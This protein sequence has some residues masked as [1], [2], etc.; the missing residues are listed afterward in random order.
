MADPSSVV[1]WDT[2]RRDETKVAILKTSENIA[3]GALSVRDVTTNRLENAENAGGKIPT[4]IVLDDANLQSITELIG[5]GDGSVEIST[6]G[7]ITLKSVTVSGLVE[8]DIFKYVYATDGQ[9]LSLTKPSSG[10]PIGYVAKYVSAGVGDVF[11]FPVSLALLAA[12]I[13]RSEEILLCN[14]HTSL[15]EGTSAIT[16]FAKTMHRRGKI[17]GLKAY[18]TAVDSGLLAGDQDLNLEIDGTDVTGGVLT[19]GFGDADAAADIGT[20][21]A[22]TAVTA[23]NT[24]IEGSVVELEMAAS[25]TGFT[26]GENGSF[27]I[28]MTVEYLPG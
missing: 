12:G 25:G 22:A 14:V 1:L 28:V 26:A 3:K 15:L 18:P 5:P 11:L 17:T 10:N 27:A 23:A 2:S 7:D 19:L 9:T 8:A 16:I 6:E 4:G 20:A 24:F 21:V 13:P